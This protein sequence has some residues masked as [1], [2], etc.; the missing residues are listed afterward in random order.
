M[1]ENTLAELYEESPE[2]VAIMLARRVRTIDRGPG[3]KESGQFMEE[4]ARKDDLNPFRVFNQ[5]PELTRRH[6]RLEPPFE[7]GVVADFERLA[8]E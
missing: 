4:I 8:N 5:Y 6:S 7:A 3:R 1:V 2:L